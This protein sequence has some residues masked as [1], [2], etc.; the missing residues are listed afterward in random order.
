MKHDT[1]DQLAD[2]LSRIS[3]VSSATVVHFKE[4]GGT[5]ADSPEQHGNPDDDLYGVQFY[6]HDRMIPKAVIDVVTEY[7]TQGIYLHPDPGVVTPRPK[8]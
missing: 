6:A 7:E 8:Q 1:A 2:D 5:N 4:R 3:D